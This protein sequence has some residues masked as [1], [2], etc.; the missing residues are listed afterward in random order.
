MAHSQGTYMLPRG[1]KKLGEL[2]QKLYVATNGAMSPLVGSSLNAAGYDK[3]YS[4]AVASPKPAPTWNDVM[5][6]QGDTIKITVPIDLDV[7][8]AG[9]GLLVDGIANKL[10]QAGINAF[11]ID[12]SGDVLAKG[13]V[14]RIGLENPYDSTTVIGAVEIKNESLCASATNRRKWGN[15]WHHVLNAKSGR[16][17]DNVVATWVIAESTMLADG[18]STA[19]FF[20]SADKLQHIAPF[21]YVR[22]LSDGTIE[23]SRRFVGQLFI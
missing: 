8:A 3:E 19:L 17:V 9:K 6:W 5:Q 4:F 7:G 15:G 18:L 10:I 1:G 2:Y 14:Q 11:T 13:N 12:A 20:V 23:H 16:P 21:D 22:V